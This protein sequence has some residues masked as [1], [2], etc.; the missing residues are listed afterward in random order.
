MQVV[1]TSVPYRWDYLIISTMVT[2]WVLVI[3]LCRTVKWL[4]NVA[5]VVD[6]HA[7][8]KRSLISYI[9]EELSNLSHVC[10]LL[11]VSIAFEERGQISESIDHVDRV[12]DE[13]KVVES[14][15]WFVEIRLVDEVPIVLEHSKGV[16]DVICEGGALSKWVV[17]LI[18][19][20]IWVTIFQHS[21]LANCPLKRVRIG[22]A[23]N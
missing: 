9:G 6:D 5:H 20:Q 4:V 3:N 7:E 14:C 12:L 16:L 11:G 22:I 23:E 1:H 19:N 10:G 8:S 17:L 21:Q 18:D 15:A 2:L 13:V